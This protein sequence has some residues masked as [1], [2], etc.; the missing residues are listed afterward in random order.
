MK[1]FI[2]F[3]YLAVFPLSLTSPTLADGR[4][5]IAGPCSGFPV[6]LMTMD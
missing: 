2:R 1:H 6:M 4:G 5:G 3:A